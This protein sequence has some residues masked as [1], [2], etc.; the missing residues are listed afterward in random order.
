VPACLGHIY[1]RI[2][3]PQPDSSHWARSRRLGEISFCPAPRTRHK[4]TYYDRDDRRRN[5][6]CGMDFLRVDL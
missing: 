6:A 4:M 3:V 5:L 1:I 2:L